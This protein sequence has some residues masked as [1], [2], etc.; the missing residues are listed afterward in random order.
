MVVLRASTW[1]HPTVPHGPYTYLVINGS[2]Y[3]AGVWPESPHNA[4]EFS[5]AFCPKQCQFGQKVGENS[6]GNPNELTSHSEGLQGSLLNP[7]RGPGWS[8]PED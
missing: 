6:L 7:A 5:Q 3:W 8:R 4:G 2:Q 1:E